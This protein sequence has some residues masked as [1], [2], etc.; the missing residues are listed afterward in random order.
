MLTDF[1]NFMTAGL[2]NN[3]ETKRRIFSL[4]LG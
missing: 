3:F 4:H 1:R 2:S